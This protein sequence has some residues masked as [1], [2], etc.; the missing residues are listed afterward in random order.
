MLSPQYGCLMK[1]Y[2]RQIFVLIVSTRLGFLPDANSETTLTSPDAEPANAGYETGGEAL[3]EKLAEGTEPQSAK[4][5]RVEIAKS[6]VIKPAIFPMDP[7]NSVFEPYYAFKERMSRAYRF[8]F[9]ADYSILFQRASWT[10]S[11][12]KSGISHVLRFFGS[13]PK[14]GHREGTAGELVWKT[15]IRTALGDNL[16]PREL[17]FDTGS[18]LSTASYKDFGWGITNLYWRQTFEDERFGFAVGHIDPS[19]WADQYALLNAWSYFLNDAFFTNPA[20]VIPKQGF[21]VVGHFF[22]KGDFFVNAAI[23]DANGK[24][25]ELDFS[26][27]WSTREWFGWLEAGFRGSRNVHSRENTHLHYWRQD[28]RKEAGT[29]KSWGITFT[30][31]RVFWKGFATFIRAGYSEGNAA[32]MRRYIGIG[33]YSEVMDRDGI[34]VGVGWGSPTDKSLRDQVTSEVFYRAQ[35]TQQL[36]ITPNIQITYKPSFNVVKD[37]VLVA[38]IRFR[39][40]F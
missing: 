21:G 5:V 25:E 2:A 26:S 37:W 36:A 34:G 40:V 16:T 10:K 23:T 8:D 19:D 30:H 22:V 39:I 7:E 12:E 35:V 15:E 6:E 17:G 13:W 27:F 4:S 32:A 33:T 11:G 28:A 9:G 24:G 18:A 31:S 3:Q 29:T 1:R 20:E 38:G 14:F